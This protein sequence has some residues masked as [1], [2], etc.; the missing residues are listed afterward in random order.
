MNLD[1]S[2]IAPFG[3]H[4]RAPKSFISQM[5]QDS[6]IVIDTSVLLGLYRV[7]IDARYEMLRALK[8]VQQRVWVPHQV[9]LEFHRNRISAAKDQADFYSTTRSSL[10]SLRDQAIQ[11]IGEFANRCAIDANEKDEIQTELRK[12]FR[13]VESR[14]RQHEKKFDLSTD[15]VLNADPILAELAQLLD[16]RVGEPLSPE[17]DSKAR[18]E[19][20]RRREEKLPPGYKDRGKGRNADGDYLWWEQTLVMAGERE[21]PVL[22][23]SN[24]EK[25]D[26][27]NKQLNLSVGPREELI[28]EMRER[29]GVSLQIV[30]FAAFLESAGSTLST[31]VSPGTL[32]QAK[33]ASTRRSEIHSSPLI[34]SYEF[35]DRITAYLSE[36]AAFTEERMKE[37]L[38]KRQLA[39]ESDPI[40]VEALDGELRAA[41]RGH[42]LFRKHQ[43]DFEI[44]V[45][46]ASRIGD[47]LRL[48]SL[49]GP[50]RTLVV[51]KL[52][53]NRE[54][55]RNAERA[56]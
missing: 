31:T 48:P 25:E 12:A 17:A 9:A 28:S 33:M 32:T 52:A 26:W 40:A 38:T 42:A 19:A 1:S 18:K 55:D 45:T 53:D 41:E 27:I 4:W 37:A 7:T 34:V 14:V 49:D 39:E 16:G 2:F 11:K 46:D 30:T 13:G 47:D 36:M 10:E 29:A 51:R 15:R 5:M 43:R 20:E 24:D 50:L 35:C 56:D 3:A 8:A 6:L 22:I 21:L 54:A 23:I 44:A